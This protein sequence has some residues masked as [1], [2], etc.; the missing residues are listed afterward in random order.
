LNT[1]YTE[2]EISDG[3]T[4]ESP[5]SHSKRK[6]FD[7]PAAPFEWKVKAGRSQSLL[8]SF[9]HAYSGVISGFESQ[10]NLRIHVVAGLA[11][12]VLGF[13]LRIELYSW[14]ALSLAIGLVLTVEFANTALEH[15]VDLATENTYHPAAK[16]AKDT[17]AGAVLV[18]SI[19]ALVTGAFIFLPHI[20]R[21]IATALG[22]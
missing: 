20:A 17:A 9:Y 7:I 16:A 4:S 8:E 1:T 13:V 15:V 3:F 11:A 19:T 2:R 22:Q 21:L 14:I 18:A 6:I 10:R 12:I 5:N